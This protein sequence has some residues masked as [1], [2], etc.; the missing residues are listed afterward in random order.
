[1]LTNWAGFLTA[2]KTT[3]EQWTDVQRLRAILERTFAKFMLT[4]AGPPAWLT[5]K[6]DPI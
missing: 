2:L 3:A 6:P 4:T 5:A 1:V